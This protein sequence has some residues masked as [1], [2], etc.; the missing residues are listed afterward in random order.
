VSY[1]PADSGPP[2]QYR[3]IKLKITSKQKVKIHHP[4]GYYVSANLP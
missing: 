2:G 1:V 3:P 4:A